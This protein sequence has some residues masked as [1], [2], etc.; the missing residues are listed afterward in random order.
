M[1]TL[2]E[3]TGLTIAAGSGG[4]RDGHPVD[5]Y[6]SRPAEHLGIAAVT[7]TA[8]CGRRGSFTDITSA[9]AVG[10]NA[11]AAGHMKRA[12]SGFDHNRPAAAEAALSAAVV[13]LS[14][15]AAG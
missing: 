8:E 1:A 14:A 7:F 15:D 2:A 12:A 10:G 3:A 9:G 11:H 13:H 4:P 6:Q 5:G